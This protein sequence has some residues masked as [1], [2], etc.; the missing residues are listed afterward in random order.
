M[1]AKPRTW[2]GAITPICLSG[3]AGLLALS[4]APIRNDVNGS[5]RI[6]RKCEEKEKP[7]PVEALLHGNANA[8][9]DVNL[10][11]NEPYRL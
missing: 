10:L 4:D 11:K 9:I 5:N 3:I 7:R 1:R 6:S 2:S 8:T